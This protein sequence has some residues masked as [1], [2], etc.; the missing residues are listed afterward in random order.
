MTRTTGRA[1][2]QMDGRTTGQTTRKHNVLLCGGEGI[3]IVLFRIRRY[4]EL[5][6]VLKM[7]I[8]SDPLNPINMIKTNWPM[9]TT[10]AQ[11][12]PN[13]GPTSRVRWDVHYIN[14]THVNRLTNVNPYNAELFCINHGEQRVIFNMKSS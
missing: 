10:S 6:P 9:Y 5:L 1:N 4:C 7:I 2:E 11:Y 14:P 12:Q 13:T 8:M 3:T